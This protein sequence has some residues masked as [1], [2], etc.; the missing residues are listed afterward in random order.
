MKNGMYKTK[1]GSTVE[2]SGT[3]SGIFKVFF[4]WLEED[5]CCDCQVDPIPQDDGYLTWTCYVC[6]G[7][8]A[9][10]YT[11]PGGSFNT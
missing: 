7:G 4:D 2:V 10:L 6:G 1:N 3:N 8:K 11:G 5:A 9:K